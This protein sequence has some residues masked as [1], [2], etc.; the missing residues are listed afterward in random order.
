MIGAAVLL[1][2]VMAVIVRLE[3][4]SRYEAESQVVLDVR[5]THIL[6]FDAVLSG[7]PTG[8]EVLHTE[9]DV[10]NSTA[11][12]ERILDRLSRTDV[13]KLA[14]TT[15]LVTPLG[16]M[17]QHNWASAVDHIR[18]WLPAASILGPAEPAAGTSAPSPSGDLTREELVQLIMAGLKVSNDG[19]SYTIHIGFTSPDPQLAAKLANS[20]AREYLASQLD[21]KIEATQHAT[22]W[23][24]GRLVELRRDLEASEIALEKYKRASGVVDTK[25]STLA[26]QEFSNVSAELVA[27]RAQAIDAESRLNI[28]RSLAANGGGAEGLAD[29]LSS[30]VVQQLRMKQADLQRQEA[31]FKGQYTAK[32]PGLK[33]VKTDLASVQ[34]QINAETTRIIANLFNQFN[35]AQA[36]VGVLNAKL[37]L[38]QQKFGNG[39]EAE[40]K[41]RQLQREADANRSVYETYLNR[42]KETSEQETLQEADAYQI[43]SATTPEYAKYPRTRPLLLLGMIFGGLLGAGG[44]LLRETLD[45]RLRSVGQVEAAT[46]LPVL[47]LL[48]SVPRQL[49][50]EEY[51]LRRPWSPFNEAL[52]STWAALSL[53]KDGPVGKVM[54]V[55]SSVPDEGKTAYG[56]SLARSLAAD[57]HRVLLIDGD[58]RRPGVAGSLGSAKG[59]KLGDL[60]AG[61]ISL[62]EAIETDEKSGADYIGSESYD[63]HPQD[64]LS[65]RRMM[66][67]LDEARTLYDVVI[68]D[69][70]PIL[71]AADAA[72]VARYADRCL[73]FIRWGATSREHVASALNR[74]ALYN[75]RISGVVL[76]HVDMRRH[77]SYAAGEG[78]Y[79][80]YGPRERLLP[81]LKA[82]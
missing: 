49:R 33:R 25:G 14:A 81:A 8:T 78:Y 4:I 11:M 60:L 77:A 45:Q 71:V 18:A 37:T 58:L 29:V 61:R 12:A 41:L 9:M 39:G 13:Q 3:I 57:G 27:A 65:S 24:R 34:R 73:F 22:N 35:T 1:G 69:T 19:H 5:S 10:I 52:R 46:G 31:E 68:V 44:A 26:M 51:V 74:L 15:R 79:Q 70:P 30:G 48:P 75:V 80:H 2:L 23:L 36:K 76:S 42:Y 43:S 20:F 38:L 6:K 54:V 55:T 7:L 62:Q 56:L 17:L 82:P 40:V 32:Y 53:S 72:L 16:R 59:G 28:A 64:L 50:P 66:E 63:R 47:A 67:T 21:R